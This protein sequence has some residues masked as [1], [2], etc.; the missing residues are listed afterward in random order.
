MDRFCVDL[1]TQTGKPLELQQIRGF[2]ISYP[3]VPHQLRLLPRRPALPTVLPSLIPWHCPVNAK[4]SLTRPPRLATCDFMRVITGRHVKNP[5]SPTQLTYRAWVPTR[6]AIR[7]R[8][9]LQLRHA[10]THPSAEPV[11]NPVPFPSDYVCTTNCFQKRTVPLIQPFNIN[12]Q[13]LGGKP[14]AGI[15]TFSVLASCSLARPNY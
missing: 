15:S 11:P 3:P 9:R 13:A 4:A 12:T 6:Q 10:C 5:R 7:R 8:C 14:H 2:R 1:C